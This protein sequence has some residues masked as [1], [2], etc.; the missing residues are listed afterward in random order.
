VLDDVLRKTV[1][2]YA[3]ALRERRL[4]L[5]VAG[6]KGQPPFQADEARLVQTFGQLLSNAIKF[7]PDGGHLEIAA[8][9]IP[10]EIGKP[11]RLEVVFA[12]SGVGLDAS[13]LE[14]IFEKFYR[15][16]SASQHSTGK[17]KFMGAG[18][19]LGLSIARGVIE[20]HGGRVWAE[21]P[22]YNPEKLPGSRFHVELPLKPPAF[23][24]SRPAG[25]AS[26]GARKDRKAVPPPSPLVGT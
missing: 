17:T 6:I 20:R 11:A 16:G 12:D 5:K 4:A 9:T 24:T 19:G 13:Q 14:L 15:V 2:P 23:A 8:R 10:N 18:P 7:T 3:A 26:P 22:G 25:G 21:S 1:E